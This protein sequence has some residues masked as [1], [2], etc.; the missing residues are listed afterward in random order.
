MPLVRQLRVANRS[1]VGEWSDRGIISSPCCG[2]G[3][4]DDG[5]VFRRRWRRRWVEAPWLS[6][7]DFWSLVRGALLVVPVSV[8]TAYVAVVTAT[9][10]AVTA[11]TDQRFVAQCEALWGGGF[12]RTGLANSIQTAR[13]MSVQSFGRD[14]NGSGRVGENRG[15]VLGD[16]HVC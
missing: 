15:N 5:E 12:S 13:A 6:C 9:P 7:R 2:T 8:R 11:E 16:R 1:I 4:C 3:R 14:V 10:V